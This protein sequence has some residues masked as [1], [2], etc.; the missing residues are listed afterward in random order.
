MGAADT[1]D[2]GEVTRE[3]A[4]E[5]LAVLLARAAAPGAGL[6]DRLDAE[7]APARLA[8]GDFTWVVCRAFGHVGGGWDCP[9]CLADWT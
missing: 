9:R 4:E 6:L 7:E 1:F 2:H 3:H 5:A 8:D